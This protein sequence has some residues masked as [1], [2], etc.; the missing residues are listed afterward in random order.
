MSRQFVEGG[1]V[2]WNPTYGVLENSKKEEVRCGG[3]I[4]PRFKCWVKG[5]WIMV[6]GEFLTRITRILRMARIG[7]REGEE[8]INNRE[9]CLSDCR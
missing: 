8:T 6:N 2:S 7:E 5:E 1:D 9:V 3:G 4:E